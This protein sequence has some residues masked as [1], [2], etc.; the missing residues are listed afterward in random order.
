MLGG[1]RPFV[2]RCHVTQVA[3][4]LLP[5]VGEGL[6][7]EEGGGRGDRGHR[8]VV[9]GERGWWQG[10]AGVVL[11]LL[12]RVVVREMVRGGHVQVGEGGVSHGGAWGK[13]PSCRAEAQRGGGGGS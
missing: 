7:L 9:V 2:L 13:S 1:P 3:A 5:T 4:V 10:R 6:A 11:L 12:R 8:Q